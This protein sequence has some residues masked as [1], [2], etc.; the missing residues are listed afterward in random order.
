MVTWALENAIETADSMKSRGYGLK[1]RSA[2]S[3]YRFDA[4]DRAALLF[5]LTC[6][7]F[8]ILGAFLGVLRWRYYPT[9]KGA[10]TGIFSISCYL[11][12]FALC[13]TPVIINHSEDKKWRALRSAA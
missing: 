5:L 10:G 13:M 6:G 4:R 7:A 2:F 1:G 12:Y 3:I 11:C 9:M 8:I